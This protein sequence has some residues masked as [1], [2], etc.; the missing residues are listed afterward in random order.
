MEGT[1][2]LTLNDAT[3]RKAVEHY[4][5]AL[6]FN[7]DARVQVA[8]VNAERRYSEMEYEITLVPQEKKS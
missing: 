2:K 3:M 6:V 4:L 7:E 5:N 8:S 1:N